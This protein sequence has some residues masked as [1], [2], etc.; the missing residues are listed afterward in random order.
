MI[1][2]QQFLFIALFFVHQCNSEEKLHATKGVPQPKLKKIASTPRAERSTAEGTPEVQNLLFYKQFETRLKELKQIWNEI[3]GQKPVKEEKRE[4]TIIPVTGVPTEDRVTEEFTIK[5]TE[6]EIPQE[7]PKGRSILTDLNTEE[8]HLNNV[9]NDL[10]NGNKN[11]SNTPNDLSNV[12]ND[13]TDD[14]N[15]LIGVEN[16][17]TDDQ[18][19][20]ISTQ[21][22]LSN[23]Q[24]ENPTILT[25]Q[26]AT[27]DKPTMA[28]DFY[29]GK[30]VSKMVNDPL[31]LRLILEALIVDDLDKKRKTL[32]LAEVMSEIQDNPEAVIQKANEEADHLLRDKKSAKGELISDRSTQESE[33]TLDEEFT[34]VQ[35][36]FFGDGI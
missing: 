8:D 9:L 7:K 13:L 28:D 12:P 18:N 15:N 14:K 30:F 2:S 4:T 25:Q 1:L 20:L 36:D 16:N 23:D 31:M 35:L 34:D 6:T 19:D 5:K 3:R 33:L 27:M 24:N 10:S 32:N 26:N 17:V 22:N 29:N 11:L 21:N